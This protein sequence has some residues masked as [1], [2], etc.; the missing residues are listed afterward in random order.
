MEASLD[1]EVPEVFDMATVLVDWHVAEPWG[2][3]QRLRIG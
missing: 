2:E 1:L 3:R